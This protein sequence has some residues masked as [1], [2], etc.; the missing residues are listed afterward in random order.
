MIASGM[1]RFGVSRGCRYPE[2]TGGRFSGFW[3][4]IAYPEGILFGDV[5]L[6]LEKVKCSF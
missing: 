4:A 1:T 3:G 5:D 2:L 6:T